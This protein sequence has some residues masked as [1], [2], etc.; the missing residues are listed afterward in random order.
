M[1]SATLTVVPAQIL[2]RLIDDLGVT[3]Q[4]VRDMFRIDQRTLDRWLS[5]EAHPQRAARARLSELDALCTHLDETFADMADARAWLGDPSRYLGGLTPLEA[6][7]VGRIDRVEAA[8]EVLDSG[9]F[10]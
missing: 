10:S 5:G 2:R 9:I 8:L 1:R 3:H 4:D 6:L 7:R